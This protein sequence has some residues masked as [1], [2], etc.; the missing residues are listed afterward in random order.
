MN[1]KFY[2]ELAEQSLNGEVLNNE[3]SGKILLDKNIELLPLLHAAYTVRQKY[4]SRDVMIHIINN[5]QN[6]HC[7]E[8]CHYCAQAK[9]SKAEIEEYPLKSDYEFLAEAKNAYEKGAYRYCMVFAGRGP[10]KGRVERL[11]NL[12]RK[13]KAKYPIEICVSAGLLDAQKAAVLKEAGLDRLNHNLNTSEDHYPN[14]CTTHTFADRLQTLQAARQAG[15]QLCSGVIIGMEETADDII[16]A[17][18]KLREIG[19]VSI[20][21][22][23][24]IPIEGNL[25]SRMP[26]LTPEFCLRILCLY[27][28][29]NPKAEIRIAAGR[30]LH[31]RSMEVLALYPAN[32]L[33]LDGYL[34]TRGEERLKTLQMIKDAGFQIRSN[35]PLDKLIAAEEMQSAAPPATSIEKRLMKDLKDLRPHQ[36][37]PVAE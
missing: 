35:Y 3:I 18:L 15:I 21:V 13:I 31:L 16:K 17:A 19:V 1:S 30:E 23:F 22:N 20:P 37:L 33:F 28:F 14:I 12:I 29:L 27:R 8:D 24:L 25:F 32:S 4:C 7:P 11:A 2:T 26:D 10:S 9:T 34:N 6:G 5:A 36:T